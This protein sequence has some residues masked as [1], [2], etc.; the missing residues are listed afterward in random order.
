M[1]NILNYKTIIDGKNT[2]FDLAIR[3]FSKSVFRALQEENE[4]LLIFPEKIIQ[5]EL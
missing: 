3:Q 2:T 5:D 4:N 1:V